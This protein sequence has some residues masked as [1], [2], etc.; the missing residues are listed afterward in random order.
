MRNCGHNK[1]VN[2]LSLVAAVPFKDMHEFEA[3]GNWAE[4]DPVW[5]SDEAIPLL[6]V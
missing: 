5:A 6:E 2:G 4:V 1:S 3:R